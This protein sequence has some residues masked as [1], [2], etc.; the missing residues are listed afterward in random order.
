MPDLQPN[1]RIIE[2]VMTTSNADGEI[3][4]APM[5]PIVTGQGDDW[6]TGACDGPIESFR[7]RPFKTST[8]YQNL[9]ARGEGVFHTT[10]DVLL[11]A[12][13][14][15]GKV[16]A[17]DTSAGSRTQ[18]ASKVHGVVLSH[19]CQAFELKV[20]HIDDSEDRTEIDAQVVHV[21]RLRDFAGFNR[22]KSA[23]LEAAIL[24]TRLHLT[25]TRPVLDA[26]EQLQVAVN[27]TGAAREHQAMRELWAFV[28]GAEE[29]AR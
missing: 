25:G 4:I 12:R 5:G 16:E 26:F 11:I 2:G 9:K 21:T 1:Q 10:D 23:V 19:A 22:A 13:G 18:P 27:K 3:N 14:A 15:I 8:T 6:G 20:T 7:F 24:A 29:A 28:R 17:G